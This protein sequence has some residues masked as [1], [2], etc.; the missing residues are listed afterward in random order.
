MKR[1]ELADIDS[2]FNGEGFKSVLETTN[3]TGPGMGIKLSGI[4]NLK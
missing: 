2:G 3:C 1:T 4:K